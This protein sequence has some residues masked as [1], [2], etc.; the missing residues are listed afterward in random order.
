MP[1]TELASFG[2]STGVTNAGDASLADPTVNS[3]GLTCGGGGAP[4][5]CAE[6]PPPLTELCV[7]EDP[8]EA[9]G[10]ASNETSPASLLFLHPCAAVLALLLAA[11]LELG[12]VKKKLVK[13]RSHEAISVPLL[14]SK[15]ALRVGIVILFFLQGARGIPAA[16]LQV[17]VGGGPLPPMHA[18]GEW[19]ANDGLA[20]ASR[21]PTKESVKTFADC[22]AGITPNGARQV[23]CSAA[24]G[25]CGARDCSSRPGGPRQCCM[26]A[27]V[28]AGR[29]CESRADVACILGSSNYIGGDG[30]DPKFAASTPLTASRPPCS[31]PARAPFG[32]MP[33]CAVELVEQTSR[34]P[35]TLGRSFGCL[36]NSSIWV[37]N[38]RGSFKCSPDG[39]VFDCGYPPGQRR[40]R[41]HCDSERVS[42]QQSRGTYAHPVFV[43]AARVFAPPMPKGWGYTGH[44]L[45]DIA[46][47]LVLA[48][49]FNWTAARPTGMQLDLPF[50]AEG[51][52]HALPAQ[53]ISAAY[54]QGTGCYANAETTVLSKS[55]W[56]GYSSFDLLHRHVRR[57]LYDRPGRCVCVTWGFRVHL[58]QLYAFEQS[59]YAPAGAY[60][61]TA[62]KLRQLVPIQ[63]PLCAPPCTHDLAIHIRRGDVAKFLRGHFNSTLARIRLAIAHTQAQSIVFLTEK[64]NSED[65]FAH[66]C[67]GVQPLRGRCDVV[68]ST[69]HHD[70]SLGVAARTFLVDSTSSVTWLIYHLRD[71]AAPSLQLRNV[72]HFFACTGVPKPANL[73]AL[74]HS[75]CPA[76]TV[77]WG[78][79]EKPVGHHPQAQ[80]AAPANADVWR[81]LYDSSTRTSQRIAEWTRR[82]E[83]QPPLSDVDVQD[84]LAPYTSDL[85]TGNGYKSYRAELSKSSL[86]F[87]QLQRHHLSAPRNSRLLFYGHSF[88]RQLF[89]AIAPAW[90]FDKS[91]FQV[92]IDADKMRR[93]SVDIRRTPKGKGLKS[94]HFSEY[95]DRERNVTTVMVSNNNL[96][97]S[98]GAIK[99]NA[100]EDFM[101]RYAFDVVFYMDPHA[102]CVYDYLRVKEILRWSNYTQ[103]ACINLEKFEERRQHA[104][105]SFGQYKYLPTKERDKQLRQI[106]RKHARKAWIEVWPWG[107][108]KGAPRGCASG[109]TVQPTKLPD[110]PSWE[111]VVVAGAFAKK[112]C[113]NNDKACGSKLAAHQCQ[114]SWLQ[115]ATRAMVLAANLSVYYADESSGAR[116]KEELHHAAPPPSG[117]VGNMHEFDATGALSASPR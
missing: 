61:R 48:E 2:G 105:A 8:I 23:C 1:D 24:C 65:V 37:K 85:C 108:T 50:D 30:K 72:M 81:A 3:V 88:M 20:N 59:G 35:C 47:S 60:N 40:Y 89:W 92:K 25:L 95:Y 28:R 27:I 62:T 41:C 63:L 113:S 10:S 84:L 29:V 76:Q 110:G 77:L 55:A 90:S 21:V 15:C 116:G 53:C 11:C 94:Q 31:P 5:W 82:G 106:T 101:R 66:A 17:T 32:V 43:Y 42:A 102:E 26:R 104:S 74:P 16:P 91:S 22:S 83:A 100:L 6:P 80:G 58:H 54:T 36:D 98:T 12:Q 44:Q 99:S 69:L 38:C 67:T 4:V 70:V 19:R 79:P 13:G 93:Y 86:G 33:T 103:Y 97:Q 56:D 87:P 78:R 14:A 7:S 115:F 18:G 68:S 46:S 52:L 112:A 49:L 9:S 117:C 114:P 73:Q 96:L 71:A 111:G 64:R 75:P 45:Q 39:E 34:A 107:K 51:Q 57:Q 109:T